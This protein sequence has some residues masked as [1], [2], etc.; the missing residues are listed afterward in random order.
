MAMVNVDGS[1]HLWVD[2]QSKSAGLVWGLAVT[3]RSVCIHQMN[4]VNSRSDHDHEDSTIN[5]VVELFI[6]IIIIIIIIMAWVQ[7]QSLSMLLSTALSVSHWH[8]MLLPAA[9]AAYAFSCKGVSPTEPA[10]QSIHSSRSTSCCAAAASCCRHLLLDHGT[11]KPSSS[12]KTH[13][14]FVFLK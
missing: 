10:K 14:T 7:W 1:S 8:K 3:R 2:S 11:R 6:I 4:R 9:E 13:T 12:C 5:I